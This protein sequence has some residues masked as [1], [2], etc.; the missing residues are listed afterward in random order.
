MQTPGVEPVGSPVTV[1]AALPAA[2]AETKSPEEE[3]RLWQRLQNIFRRHAEKQQEEA[4]QPSE[5]EVSAERPGGVSPAQAQRS[6]ETS[7]SK[8]VAGP[9]RAKREARQ[10]FI[11]ELP[12][13]LPPQPVLPPALTG[14]G[15][16]RLPSVVEVEASEREQQ[17]PPEKALKAPS[18]LRRTGSPTRPEPKG[19]TMADGMAA[20]E[21]PGAEFLP[22]AVSR[23]PPAG[24]PAQ[25]GERPKEG[26]GTGIEMPGGGTFPEPAPAQAAQ[27]RL[28]ESPVQVGDTGAVSGVEDETLAMQPASRGLQR[29][30]APREGSARQAAPHEAPP[31]DVPLVQPEAAAEEAQLV[32]LEA[33][34]PV[35]RLA[36]APQETPR[37]EEELPPP[38]A[39]LATSAEAQQVSALLR[40]VAPGQPTESTV[41][42][43]TPRR[44]R[45]VPAAAHSTPAEGQPG[46]SYP[47][48]GADMPGLA[49]G[50]EAAAVA[51][52][53]GPL[54]ADLWSLI[55]QEPPA[56]RAASAALSVQPV[57]R[58]PAGEGNL[59]PA[60]PLGS[61]PEEVRQ[62][63]QSG[64]IISTLATGYLSPED[65]PN[66]IQMQAAEGETAPAPPAEGAPG[67]GAAAEINV[68]ELTRKVYQEIKRRLSSEWERMRRRF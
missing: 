8:P 58:Q 64:Q 21:A 39:S 2:P 66:V 61:Q 22:K 13:G 53:I 56:E 65:L 36:D 31:L 67:E 20:P 1:P 38:S 42:V 60:M 57:Q 18:V 6:E 44:P 47:K 33:A 54:P 48:T 35:Q 32:P 15:R 62:T 49:E 51:T 3:E 16:P 24:Q 34:W 50:V 28:E 46:S 40:E 30:T 27:Q 43:V 55:G 68:D 41:E 26:S 29:A 12:E 52:E 11:Q 7:V 9:E 37:Q 23:V 25:S 45:P 5:A 19:E 4:K 63:S 17:K 59:A 10:P 14:E